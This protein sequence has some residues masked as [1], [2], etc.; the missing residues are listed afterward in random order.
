ME[1][2]MAGAR[3]AGRVAFVTGAGSGIGRATA[4]LFAA[5]G[6]RVFGVDVNEA[7]LGET[8]AAIREAGGTADGTGCDVGSTPAVEAAVARAVER[9]GGLN[10]LVNAAGVGRFARLEEI[11]EAEFL[12]TVGVNLGGAFRT[13]K[14]ALPHLLR[15][16]VGN[17]VNVA[18]TAAMRGNAYA[19]VYA[20]SKA[21]LLNFTRSLA[22]EF[23]SRDLRANCVCPG[24]VKT[25]FGRN[26]PRREDFEPHL[27]DYQAP[28]KLGTFSDPEDIAKAICFLASDDARFVSGAALLVDAG[29][30]A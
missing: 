4:R 5:E 24:G 10:V 29:T 17:I 14:A 7:G 15:P 26:F 12:R 16:P 30:L 11:D 6:A 19:S 28:P 25:P 27:I 20:A 1:V 21:G 9:L 22:L 3:F 2:S 8:V 18:S 13:V 23:A